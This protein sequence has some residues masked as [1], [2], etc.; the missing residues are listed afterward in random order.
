MLY[1]VTGREPGPPLIRVR[2]AVGPDAE[3]AGVLGLPGSP[4]EWAT[5]LAQGSPRLPVPEGPVSPH[6]PVTVRYQIPTTAGEPS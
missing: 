3:L 6:G 1:P 2:V 4:G 5:A